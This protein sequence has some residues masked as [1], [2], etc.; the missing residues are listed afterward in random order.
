MVRALLLEVPVSMS[1]FIH[2]RTHTLV[3]TGIMPTTSN[4][5]T[6]PTKTGG[7]AHMIVHDSLDR[8]SE[9]ENLTAPSTLVASWYQCIPSCAAA[10]Y[11]YAYQEHPIAADGDVAGP[12]S[13]ASFPAPVILS[14]SHPAS[15][16]SCLSH[17]VPQPSC[18]TAILSPNHPASQ[19]SCLPH[20]HPASQPSCHA[21]ILPRS[22][23]ACLTAILSHSHPASQPSC[24]PHSHPACLTAILPQ[25]SCP[26][27]I[28]SYY[29]TTV[30][31]LEYCHD[32]AVLKCAVL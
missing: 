12:A 29:A 10:A 31:V 17:P 14:H 4:A 27:A 19:P 6:S 25:P 18:L 20:S 3:Q 21:A 26:T 23:P 9:Y 16:P 13:S 24:L 2:V 28:L 32:C 5:P 30:A 15:R 8:L 11:R 1:P 22:H 7:R